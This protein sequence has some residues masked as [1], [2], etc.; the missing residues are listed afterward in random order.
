MGHPPLGMCTY[1]VGGRGQSLL[2]VYWVLGGELPPDLVCVQITDTCN[3]CS[4]MYR[5]NKGQSNIG[6]LLFLHRCALESSFFSL[7]IIDEDISMVVDSRD[8]NRYAEYPIPTHV[9]IH[10]GGAPHSGFQKAHSTT[11]REPGDYSE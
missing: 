2:N 1:T 3:I 7:S 6:L 8:I 10:C 5:C 4:D 11:Q 9:H